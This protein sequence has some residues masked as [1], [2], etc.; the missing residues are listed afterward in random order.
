ME[1]KDQQK[2]YAKTIHRRLDSYRDGL[3]RLERK[4]DGVLDE[5]KGGVRGGQSGGSG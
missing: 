5:I 3:I 4:V 1:D 2:E